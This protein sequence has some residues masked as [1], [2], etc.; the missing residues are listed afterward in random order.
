MSALQKYSGPDPQLLAG[1]TKDDAAA[2]AYLNS[3]P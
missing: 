2:L 3:Q 1:G